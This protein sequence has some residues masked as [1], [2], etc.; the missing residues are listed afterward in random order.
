MGGVGRR[1]GGLV[2]REV[3]EGG[4]RVAGSSGKVVE[5]VESIVAGRRLVAAVIYVAGCPHAVFVAGNG[6]AVA[7]GAGGCCVGFAAGCSHA[8]CA[9]DNVGVAVARCACSSSR[10]SPDFLHPCGFAPL[11]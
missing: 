6:V 2:V 8:V 1:G 9:V 7:A 10:L 4:E 3:G 5:I 11:V